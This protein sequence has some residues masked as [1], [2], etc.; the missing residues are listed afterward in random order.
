MSAPVTA[1]AVSAPSRRPR[2]STLLIVVVVL[3]GAVLAVW[4]GRG[5]GYDDPL[6]PRNPGRNGAEATARVLSD[7]GVDVDVV[8]GQESLLGAR[9]DDGTAVVVSNPGDLGASTLSALERRARTGAGLVVLGNGTAVAD[10]FTAR[11]AVR[12]SG[13]VGADCGDPL[14]DGLSIDV[15]DGSR[16]YTAGPSSCFEGL[17]LRPGTE[18]RWLLGDSILRN[19]RVTRADNAAVA[20]RLLGQQPRLVW[21]VADRADLAAGDGVSIGPL[22]PRW[23]VPGLVLLGLAGVALLVWQAR[24]LGPLVSEPLPVVVRAIE[25]TDS[26]GRLYRRAGDRDHAARVLRDATRRRL[27][28]RLSLRRDAAVEDVVV[29]TADVLGRPLDP[30]RDLL[31]DHPVRSESALADL[32]RDL[33]ALEEE[34]HSR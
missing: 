6:D 24:R 33:L 15:G 18:T 26:R 17:L 2:R 23:L 25:S 16:G 12:R 10:R 29:A 8:R 19:D 22:L 28:R 30:V 31:E 20:L 14:V 21:Y 13:T 27:A 11:A 32:G 34:V 1:R 4:A 9:V 5:S 7:R 3:A